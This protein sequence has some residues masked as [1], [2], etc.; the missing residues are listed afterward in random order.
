MRVHISILLPP[1]QIRD[2][3][4]QKQGNVQNEVT[5]LK[6]ILQ[7]TIKFHIK[8]PALKNRCI[9]FEAHENNSFCNVNLSRKEDE[10]GGQ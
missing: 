8:F 6:I 10:R 1:I 3:A 9:K 4:T 7:F 2:T 5:L